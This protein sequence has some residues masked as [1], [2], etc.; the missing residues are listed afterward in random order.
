M[1]AAALAVTGCGG[2]ERSESADRV[3]A[4]QIVRVAFPERQHL[5][6]RSTFAITARNAGDTTI[7]SVVGTL[8]G[9]ASRAADGGDQRLWIADE[10]RDPGLAALDDARATGPLEPGHEVVLRWLLTAT[11]AGTHRLSWE[12]PG[13]DRPRGTLTVRV[14]ERPPFARVDPRTGAVSREKPPRTG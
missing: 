2:G 4:V 11:A 10:P 9:L 12:V 6:Q 14:A 13:G 7:P 1:A 5:A 3:H 8:S